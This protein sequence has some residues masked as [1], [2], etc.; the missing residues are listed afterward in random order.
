MK[1][2]ELEDSLRKKAEK[3]EANR[4]AELKSVFKK[5]V[6]FFIIVIIVISIPILLYSIYFREWYII[7]NNNN[8]GTFGD[9]I[10]GVL[11]PLLSFAAF[12][13]LLYTIYLQN[14]ELGLT[15]IEVESSNEALISQ[16]VCLEEQ[17]NLQKQRMVE[18][19]YFNSLRTYKDSVNSYR[20]GHHESVFI[21]IQALGRHH[22]NHSSEKIT[23][24][25]HF[26]L[27]F[28]QFLKGIVN[29]Y[30]TSLLLDNDLRSHYQT[31]FF[32]SISKQ[33]L[34][35]FSDITHELTVDGP[36][37]NIDENLMW[38]II[39]GCVFDV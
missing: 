16:A 36:L 10:G 31:I 35:L 5:S 7:P 37:E 6:I 26:S 9:F 34:D 18:S 27:E 3:R 13:A 33:E 14:K 15:R 21:G 38:E 23:N 29:V 20:Y 17:S 12:I 24:K 11:N 19:I 2:T 28:S 25:H 22:Y 32:S 8:W 1:N 39:C 4:E 30:N